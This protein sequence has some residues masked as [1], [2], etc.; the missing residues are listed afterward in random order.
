MEPE[1]VGTFIE[2]DDGGTHWRFDKAFL[3]SNW[4][5]IWGRGCLGI[6][7]EPAEALGQGCCSVGAEFGDQ[8]EAR[9]TSALAAMLE[10]E[11]FQYHAEAKAGG[12]FSDAS[13]TNT[14]VVDGACIFLNRPGFANGPGCALHQAAIARGESYLPWKPEVCW[15][16]PLRREDD[17]DAHGHVTSTVRE[18]KRRDWGEGGREFHWWCTSDPEA[19]IAADPVYVRLEEELVELTSQETYDQLVAYIM[20]IEVAARE[21]RRVAFLPHP[22][23]RQPPDDA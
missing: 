23:A 9:M 11:R 17:T 8:D 6:L 2:I 10:P 14:R 4:T 19:F 15:Q 16:L 1:P 22:A 3:E 13:R 18:W 12:I 7:D 21:H 20:E 5:C